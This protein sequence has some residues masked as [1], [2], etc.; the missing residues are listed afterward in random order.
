MMHFEAVAWLKQQIT[1]AVSSSKTLTGQSPR[2]MPRA[3]CLAR[4]WHRTTPQ[5]NQTRPRAKLR[6]FYSIFCTCHL[7]L[8]LQSIRYDSLT[9]SSGNFAARH[10]YAGPD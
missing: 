5:V 9:E 8:R 3:G 6:W 2:S 10:L 4:N 7:N 1:R